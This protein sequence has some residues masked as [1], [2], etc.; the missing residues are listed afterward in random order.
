LGTQ[1]QGY[2]DV[3]VGFVENEQVDGNTV[4]RNTVDRNTPVKLLEEIKE[5]KIKDM[6]PYGRV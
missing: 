2:E 1:D 3:L 6:G 4:D 5:Y